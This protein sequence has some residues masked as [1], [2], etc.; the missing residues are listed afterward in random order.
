VPVDVSERQLRIFRQ[1]WQIVNDRYI[2]ADFNGYD[3]P[4][5]KPDIEARIKAGLSD[6]M[7]Y[8]LMRDLIINLNDDHSTF[9][10]PP[11]AEAE[12]REYAGD[13]SYVGIGIYVEGNTEK[14]YIYVL[15][16]YAGSPAEAAG[17]KPH[18]HILQIDG[19]PSV[20]EAGE[21]QDQLMRGVEGTQVTLLVRTPGEQ[22]RTVKVTRAKVSASE[23]VPYQILPTALTGRKRI[24]YILIPTLFE[25]R[26]A[27]RVRDALRALA[28]RGRLDGL[29]VDMRLNGGGAYPQL[30]TVLGF[31]TR[32]EMGRLEDRDGTINTITVR[33]ERVGNS[34]TVPLVVL[35]GPATASYAEVFA[36]S[37]QAK[38]R[39]KLVGLPSAGNIET[40]LR[41]D[42]E[43]GS[44]AWI[45]Q[46]TFK[47]PDG[48]GWEG[49]GLQPDVRVQA[50]WDEFTGNDDPVIAAAVHTLTK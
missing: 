26:M 28:R 9:L 7:F 10:S 16:V 23:N 24:G 46:E 38:G 13:N 22:V 27:V 41:H 42:F 19:K 44:V 18:D 12:A 30:S 36:G 20:N 37:L 2:Y 29:I 8:D 15:R 25:E 11:E 48:S 49:V 3:W 31:F 45:A 50:N 6:E 39:A 33:A 17:V 47:L 4:G 32:G 40:L 14:R 43:D 34:Q 21:L 35:I 1:L 5:I